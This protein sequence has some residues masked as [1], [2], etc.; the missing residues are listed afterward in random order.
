MTQQLQ[1]IFSELL[2]ELSQ[3]YEVSDIKEF[4]VKNGFEWHYSLV[5]TTMESG[6]PLILGFNWGAS[7]KQ[8]YMPET[9]I[10]KS[11]FLNADV[12]SLSRIF[13]FCEKYFGADFLTKISQSNYCFFRSQTESQIT[14]KDIALCEPVFEKLINA[15]QPSLILCFSSKL[16]DYLISNNKILSSE[17]KEI[18]FK[19]GSSVVTYSTMRAILSTGIEIK[20]L[21]HPNYPIRQN[22]RAQAWEFCCST[23]N[24]T[25]A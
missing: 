15:I 18:T 16:R 20:F 10:E 9:S 6:G 25:V 1:T 21:P 14:S 3:L 2:V 23:H 7:L 17:L 22:A 13:P 24:K 19:R 12:G 5:T 4:C 11:D 8:K